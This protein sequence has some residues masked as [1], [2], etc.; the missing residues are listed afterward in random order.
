M[1]DIAQEHGAEV[2][3][4]GTVGPRQCTIDRR[5][6]KLPSKRQHRVLVYEAGP[7]GSWF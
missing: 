5:I 3:Y 7:C 1:A 2:T 4:L 6:R